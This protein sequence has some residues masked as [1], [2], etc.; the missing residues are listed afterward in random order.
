MSQFD[1][2]FAR[3]GSCPRPTFP[4]R[5]QEA[6]RP[7]VCVDGATVPGAFFGCVQWIVAPL[8]T[9]G[10]VRHNCD[11]LHMFVGGDVKNHEALGATVTMQLENDVLTFSETS[12]VFVPAGCAHN[13]VSVTDV[14]KPFLHYI[15]HISAPEYLAE[16]AEATAP[17]GT[18]LRNRVVRYVR[19][20][21]VTPEAPEGFLTFLLWIDGQKVPGAP[22]TESV[23]FHQTN[24][25]GPET[26]VHDD[27][28]EFV[29]F[30]GSD[31]EHPEELCGDIS[32]YI[33]GETVHT[34]KS[35]LAF[36]PR[37][38]VHSPILV[39][40]LEKDILHFTGGNNSTYVRKQR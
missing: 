19:D 23:W 1:R 39:H 16:P 31:P 21:G 24:D 4:C 10:L 12:F 11:E 5:P 37:N 38:I 6:L 3:G 36:V 32:L 17:A 27:L 8:T 35:T 22:Y 2:C 20:D 9:Q 18:Y 33:G 28:D 13:V 14:Q 7:A 15:M 40:K 25:T 34:T 29:A 26:H 30:I